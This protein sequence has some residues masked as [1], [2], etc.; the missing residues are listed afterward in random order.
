MNHFGHNNQNNQNNQNHP[1][2]QGNYNNQGYQ[3]NPNNYGNYNP[4]N[5]V[6]QQNSGSYGVFTKLIPWIAVVFTLLILLGSYVSAY[7]YGN[8]METR[9]KSQH[10]NMEN[11]L[12][13]YSQ[14]IQE[15]M[16][17]PTAYKDDLKEILTA[18]M[19]GRYGFTTTTTSADGK[20]TQTNNNE[21]RQGPLM[22]FMNEHNLNLDSTM[23]RQ[24]Q[25]NIEAGRQKFEFENKK[26][27]DIKNE[28]Q[29]SL[30][31]FYKGKW[32]QIAGYPKID[33]DKFDIVSNGYARQSFEKGMETGPIKL[34]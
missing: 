29:T 1:N 27:I 34:R 18:T 9:I 17:V 3:N 5:Q 12:A 24:V 14:T 13:Q 8:Q 6:N 7:N 16:Q 15:L 4:Q 11:V 2:N 19:Q 31:S 21:S 23:Y 26:L 32:M 30:G 28:Y 10:K 20:T 33:L 25:Q 22:Q